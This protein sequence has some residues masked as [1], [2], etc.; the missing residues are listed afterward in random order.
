MIIFIMRTL[1]SGF[2]SANDTGTLTDFTID[3]SYAAYF[4]LLFYIPLQHTGCHD[5]NG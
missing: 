5:P 2:Y 3:L 4:R 1:E